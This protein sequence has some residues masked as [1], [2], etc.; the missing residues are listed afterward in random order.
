LA[1]LSPDADAG[2]NAN[3]HTSAGAVTAFHPWALRSVSTKTILH[4]QHRTSKK[5]M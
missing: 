3:P 1:S 2:G 5:K 4:H